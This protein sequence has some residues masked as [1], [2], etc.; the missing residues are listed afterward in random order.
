MNEWM[1]EWGVDHWEN[2]DTVV[3]SKAFGFMSHSHVMHMSSHVFC[4]GPRPKPHGSWRY[5][6]MDCGLH[7]AVTHPLEYVSLHPQCCMV[8]VWREKEFLV[9]LLTVI[10]S[11]IAWTG[12]RIIEVA[13]WRFKEY[14]S[15]AGRQAMMVLF[16]YLN[17]SAYWCPTPIIV[18]HSYRNHN[19]NSLTLGFFY[20]SFPDA[21]ASST[22]DPCKENNVCQSFDVVFI[23]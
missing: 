14:L 1:N 20:S 11:A 8:S 13:S 6:N 21:A 23:M 7:L 12:T 15:S 16:C 5:G 10:P 18:S 19:E 17:S 9:Y 4:G 2:K 22:W 3:G